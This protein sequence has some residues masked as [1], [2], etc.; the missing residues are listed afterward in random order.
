M[1][2]TVVVAGLILGFA[3]ALVL[4][5]FGWFVGLPLAGLTMFLTLRLTLEDRWAGAVAAPLAWLLV[6]VVPGQL[7]VTHD[8]S[9]V[10]TQVLLIAQGLSDNAIWIVVPAVVGAVVAR[11]RGHHAD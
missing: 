6:I 9:V 7:T 5:G 8:G 2:V 10:L 4:D 11:R 3:T 1:V